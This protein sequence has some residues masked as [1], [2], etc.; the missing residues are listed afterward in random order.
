MFDDVVGYPAAGISFRQ[1]AMASMISP[2]NGHAPRLS[3]VNKELIRRYT[4]VVIDVKL[5]NFCRPLVDQKVWA[6]GVTLDAPTR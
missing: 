6:F 5:D 4:R 2:R 3:K 1:A